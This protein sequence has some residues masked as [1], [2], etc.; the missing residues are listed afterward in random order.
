MMT[1]HRWLH[2]HQI[3]KWKGFMLV[4]LVEMNLKWSMVD[5]QNFDN[6]KKD[7]SPVGL[8]VAGTFVALSCTCRA[9]CVVLLP[10]RD[11]MNIVGGD[12]YFRVDTV[13]VFSHT[14]GNPYM[15]M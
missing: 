4:E 5:K 1:F 8:A 11:I 9:N 6:K 14:A 12:E 10:Y 3:F 13:C 7:F 15:T 2:Q